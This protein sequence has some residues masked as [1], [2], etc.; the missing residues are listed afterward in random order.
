MRSKSSLRPRYL[1]L[2]AVLV[3]AFLFAPI[4]VLVVF[5]FNQARSGT[6]FTGFSTRWYSDLI[7][8][9]NALQAFRN[10]LKVA[11]AAT[12]VATIIGTLAALAL[13]RF[14][15]RGRAGYSTLVFVSLVM[16][17]VVTGISLLVFYAN[18]AHMRLGLTTVILSHI[19]FCIAFVVIVVKARLASFD[20]RLVE[21]AADLGATP[22]QT[23]L[24]V[25][26]PLAA[27]GIAAGAMLAFTISLDDVVITFFTSGPGSTTLPLYIYGQLRIG[28]S[29]A[30]NALSTFVLVFSLILLAI[31]GLY[32]ARAA[33]RGS[34]AFDASTLG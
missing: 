8:N 29:P 31:G 11:I 7:H 27:P 16:P 2:H 4:I 33:K 17:E 14:R 10:T 20:N 24:R 22:L 34:A 25:V 9:H 23:F 12:V 28:V 5:S 6:D 26:L 15:F 18:F 1:K 3:F 13:T 32:S 19:T 30:I 21:A